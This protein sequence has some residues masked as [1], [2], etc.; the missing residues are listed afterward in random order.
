[1][2]DLHTHSRASDGTDTPR[3]VLEA[4]ASAGVTVVALTDHD[5]TAGWD[6]AAAAVADTGVALVRG[7][8]ISTRARTPEGGISVHLLGYLH[9]REH[10]AL[11]AELQRTR[12]DRVQ[13]AR[14]MTERLAE[15][16]P[17]TWEDVVAQTHGGATVGR[18]HLADALVA[19]GVVAHRDEAFATMLHPGAPYYVPHYA[20]DTADAVRAVLAAGGVPV[21]AHPRAGRR[22]RVVTEETIAELAEVGLAGLEADHRDHSADDRDRMRGLARELG[23]LVTGASDYHGVGKQNRLGEHTTDPDVLAEIEER[24]TLEVLRPWT[25]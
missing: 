5:S 24:G 15:D 18:P 2:I 17:V 4:A 14:R 13:R 11:L 10:P 8:E 20:P 6:E 3:G 23:L 22:G 19:A 12:D 16:Y 9:D 1:M 7:I 21:M 25:R